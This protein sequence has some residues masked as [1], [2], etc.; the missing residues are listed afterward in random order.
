MVLANPQNGLQL[1][2]PHTANITIAN[3]DGAS[4]YVQFAKNE[5]QVVQE[6]ASG[7]QDVLLKVERLPGTFGRISVQFLV[8]PV[9][10]DK[11]GVNATDLQPTE[12]EEKFPILLFKAMHC[13]AT[14]RVA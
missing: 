11:R 10:L 6:P 5:P 1:G 9:K 8:N 2:R 14:L 12:G 4:G 3:S 7:Q 13:R